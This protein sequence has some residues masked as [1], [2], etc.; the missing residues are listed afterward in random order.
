MIWVDFTIRL[1]AALLLG[2]MIGAERQWRQRMSS[3][4]TNALVSVGAALFVLLS[5][6]VEQEA[7]PT[8]IAASVVS[9]IGF[10]GG[11]VILRDGLNIRGL[12]TAA[13]LWC[14]AA[15]GVL[16]GSG[17]LIA[18]SI[19]T[20]M[21]L[22]ANIG[23]R[24]LQRTIAREH[25]NREELELPYRLRIICH[26]KDE[27]HIRATLLNLI[28]EGPLVMTSLQSEDAEYAGKIEVNADLLASQGQ[29]QSIEKIVSQLSLEE[30]VSLIS[31]KVLTD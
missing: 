27:G 25:L 16:A 12:N 14:S 5:V 17:Y 11:G 1:L 4:R 6:M 26:E 10:L 30:T 21:I 23:L 20:F 15:V 18:A 22:L 19:G 31:W 28:S 7:S 3:L 9:G 13:T 24:F 29:R 8:R 2:T